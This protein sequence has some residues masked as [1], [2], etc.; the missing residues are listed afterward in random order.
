MTPT[1]TISNTWMSFEPSN[2]FEDS[3]YTD[4]KFTASKQ[5]EEILKHLNSTASFENHEQ[6]K[7]DLK[8][9]LAEDNGDNVTFQTIKIADQFIDCLPPNVPKPYVMTMPNGK[10]GFEWRTNGK[11]IALATIGEDKNVIYTANIGGRRFI[12]T[13]RFNGRT[14]PEMDS[15]LLKYFKD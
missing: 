15:Q 8:V 9:T 10:I 12:I 1:A 5:I 7:E 2:A 4:N 11:E 13:A 6:I 3:E 14:I